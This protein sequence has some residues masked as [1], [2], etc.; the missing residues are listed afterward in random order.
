MEI[1]FDS[2]QN[3]KALTE[4]L[5]RLSVLFYTRDYKKA[6]AYGRLVSRLEQ[7]L[8][9]LMILTDYSQSIC[10]LEHTADTACQICTLPKQLDFLL[11]EYIWDKAMPYVLTSGTL[12]VG[13]DFSHFKH[14]TGIE[15]VDADRILETSKAS[16]FNYRDNA[17]LYIPARYAGD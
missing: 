15:L 11:F 10:W 8:S 4:I 2:I 9:K 13:G 12:S 5:R 16:P 14:Q 1:R 3:L 7:K 6:A 17:L